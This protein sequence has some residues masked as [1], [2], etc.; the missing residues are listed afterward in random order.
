MPDVEDL[1]PLSPLQ[2]GI[3]FESVY[4]PGAGLYVEQLVCRLDGE[5][6]EEALIAACR[7]VVASHPVLRTSFRWR[8][9]DRPLQVVHAQVEV[10]L[11]REDWWA[12]GVAEPERRLEEL[13]RQDRE[14]G[15][16][17]ERAPL[18]RWM[19]V[20]TGR[21]EHLLLWT[22]HHILLDGWSFAA[23]AAEF[24]ATYAALRAGEEPRSALR[25]PFR[26]FIAW[27]G[28]RD[29]AA[30][31]SY[32][33]QAL[34]GWTEPTPLPAAH[35]T[36]CRGRSSRRVIL[37]AAET[38]ALQATARR[39]L[40]TVNSLVAGAWGLLLARWSGRTDVLFGTTVAVRPAD[41]PGV[42][43]MVG[44]FINTLPVRLAVGSGET[45]LAWLREAQRRQAELR[46]FEHAPLAQIQA[47]SEVPG[48]APLFETLLVF[49][50]YPREE[51]IR[52]HGAALGVV[53]VRAIEQVHYPLSVTAVPGAELRL[54]L[55]ARP[56]P[57]RR[58]R[59][60]GAAWAAT[61]PRTRHGR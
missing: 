34:A 28:R 29:L 5:L 12:A 27:L 43:S 22:H 4:A 16:E 14:R 52:E 31:E 40:L 9:L 41:L 50:N 17:V 44:L 30:D 38:A 39:G 42:E 49:E 51:S 60:A 25:R 19:L 37:S 55:R 46:Q 1:Y 48:G 53:E 18:L 2:E 56:L 7:R 47:W 15:F 36:D 20:R 21:R 10:D 58:R 45:L 26:D 6:D 3:L 61:H 54:E 24:L 8:E 57:H 59:G 23:V 13:L 35:S 11:R 33:R 32:W